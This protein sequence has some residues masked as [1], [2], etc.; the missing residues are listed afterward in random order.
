MLTYPDSIV[1]N[2]AK[3]LLGLKIKWKQPNNNLGLFN[4]HIFYSYTVVQFALHTQF[5][6]LKAVFS[7]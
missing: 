4:V 7:D 3:S 5:I 2:N 6:W 1:Y